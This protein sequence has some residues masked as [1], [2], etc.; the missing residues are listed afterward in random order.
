MWEIA[1][2]ARSCDKGDGERIGDHE[3]T[4]IMPKMSEREKLADLVAKR[5]KIADEIETAQKRVRER[6]AAIVVAMPV[7]EIGEREFREALGLVLK[8]GGAAAVGALKAAPPK[9]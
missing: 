9:S 3:G 5:D 2:R 7:E 4:L 8:L 6:Y 1:A